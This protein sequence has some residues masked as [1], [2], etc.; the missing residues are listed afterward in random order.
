MKFRKI[1]AAILSV[2]MLSGNF[3]VVNAIAE[4]T[5]ET[6][7]AAE[8]NHVDEA[9]ILTAVGVIE[10]QDE[11]VVW[12]E[13][14]VTKGQFLSWAL[15]F[16]DYNADVSVGMNMPWE[17]VSRGSSSY[18]EYSYAYLHDWYSNDMADTDID[19]ES[20]LSTAFALRTLIG[21]LGYA[22]VVYNMGV[23]YLEQDLTNELLPGV[24]PTIDNEMDLNDAIMMLYNAMDID[25]C[26]M[27]GGT[28]TSSEWKV[29]DGVTALAYNKDIYKIKGRVNATAI[30]TIINETAWQDHIIIGS[31]MFAIPDSSYNAYIGK[32][33]E[34]YA[35]MNEDD[36]T[37]LY[38]K[39]TGNN[40]EI[41][42]NGEDFVEFTQTRLRYYNE[43]G[44]MKSLALDDPI[45]IYNG[46][47]L[48][49][50]EFSE[51]LFD[52][53]DGAIRVLS[54]NGVY[55]VLI[56]E[57]YKNLVVGAIDENSS[58]IYDRTS[59]ATL[60]ID[61]VSNP[62]ATLKTSS[63]SDRSISE[64][65]KGNVITY[66]MSLDGDYVQ[67]VIGGSSLTAEISG[68]RLDESGRYDRIMI[69]SVEYETTK[70]MRELKDPFDSTQYFKLVSGVQYVFYIN[71][72][73]RVTA[74][75]AASTL[76]AELGYI[77]AAGLFDGGMDAF[78]NICPSDALEAADAVT[79]QCA[80]K[81]TIDG[82]RVSERSMLE[83]LGRFNSGRGQSHYRMPVL[84]TLNDEGEI[85]KVDTPYYD[86]A[87]EDA[88]TLMQRHSMADGTVK[89]KSMSGWGF[90]NHIDGKYYLSTAGQAV[91]EPEGEEFYFINVIPGD[92]T[93]Y[94]MDIYTIGTNSYIAYFAT[95][96]ISASYQDSFSDG[97]AIVKNK[98]EAVNS[99]DDV[100]QRLSISIDGKD[101]TV[102]V[103]N[104]MESIV[105]DVER[106]DI[107]RY[108]VNTKGEVTRVAVILDYSDLD[109]SIGKSG[110][111]S[112]TDLALE[113][114]NQSFRWV[115]GVV[116]DVEKD[117]GN[118]TYGNVISFYKDANCTEDSVET[119]FLRTGMV[120]RY[121][122]GRKEIEVT[123][124]N[125]DMIK[126]YKDVG[127][128][129]DLI[130][131]SFNYDVPT[132]AY[133]ISRQ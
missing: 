38:L 101:S 35:R 79:F 31:D 102:D 71:V 28:N 109:N 94:S 51:D 29:Y 32:E 49:S 36:N 95:I 77:S 15:N 26:V 62:N 12:A 91:V 122:M 30:A 85:T 54:V 78:I 56:V 132:A 130:L 11:S 81:I 128:D 27:E 105:D 116:R 67:A 127:G 89:T 75:E 22:N 121:S 64:L 61:T 66:L 20:G 47:A 69:N 87:K 9:R 117:P 114:Q 113:W 23:S 3:V 112:G 98:V 25:Y 46:K 40:E 129:A 21:A 16:T 131:V 1:F 92:M 13:E 60:K 83:Y 24:T 124:T 63:G 8:V 97:F 4:E 72:N 106:G 99:N 48:Q 57:N 104:G 42:I 53:I 18:N 126:S 44:R 80:S 90:R 50:G 43:E 100:V 6:E 119:T 76:G 37:L 45:I 7:T 82:T 123:E 86:S 110:A 133:F 118:G 84:Y 19:P 10:A 111:G 107:I 65:S 103:K 96:S 59:S 39:E 52:I 14:T 17:S 120:Y 68:T 73:G 33:A 125:A 70:E 41:V 108:A 58:V 34:G 115:V 88:N 55:D 2:M 5:V 93:E 74:V